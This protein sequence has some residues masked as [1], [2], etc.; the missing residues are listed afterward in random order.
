MLLTNIA[1]PAPVI[2]ASWA[3]RNIMLLPDKDIWIRWTNNIRRTLFGSPSLCLLFRM[4]WNR[5]PRC[6]GN[7]CFWTRCKPLCPPS[8]HSWPRIAYTYFS[9]TTSWTRKRP[10]WWRL[11]LPAQES[12][13]DPGGPPQRPPFPCSCSN[14][15]SDRSYSFLWS[16][17]FPAVFWTWGQWTIEQPSWRHRH[18]CS[19]RS[20][21]P[22]SFS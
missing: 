14:W 19:F 21:L 22:S 2:F 7:T 1:E 10:F 12:T 3:N 5:F 20:Q 11:L 18:I 17:V 15:L 13:T 4:S 9:E 16:T 8:F 6:R